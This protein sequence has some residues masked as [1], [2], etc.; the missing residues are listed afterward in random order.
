MTIPHKSGKQNSY[1]QVIIFKRQL[2]QLDRSQLKRAIF[3]PLECFFFFILPGKIM[4]NL[5]FSL[6]VQ[7]VRSTLDFK[8]GFVSAFHIQK[9]ARCFLNLTFRIM[10]IKLLNMKDS[11]ILEEQMRP[12][13]DVSNLENHAKSN[14]SQGEGNASNQMIKI[15]YI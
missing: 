13:K 14:S 4:K 9:P 12:L 15:N 5:F 7:L 10:R 3:N 2:T 11:L 6:R 1:S 8:D